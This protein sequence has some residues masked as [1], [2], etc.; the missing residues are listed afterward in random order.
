VDLIIVMLVAIAKVHCRPEL[1]LVCPREAV[2]NNLTGE[3]PGMTTR[4]TK[5]VTP[6]L[7]LMIVDT[8]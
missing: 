5:G 1:R 7:R 6:M 8:G 2:G 4:S 3:L